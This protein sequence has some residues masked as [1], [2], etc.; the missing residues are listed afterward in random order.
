[1]VIEIVDINKS[2]TALVSNN[3]VLGYK[4]TFKCPIVS[5]QAVVVPYTNR[6]DALVIGKKL[7]VETSQEAVY[8]FKVVSNGTPIKVRPL[9]EPGDYHI[10]GEIVLNT[11]NTV[12]D[13]E[14]DD[15]SF[16]IDIEESDGLIPNLGDK[17]SF[18][19]HGLAL[20]DENV[21]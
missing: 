7:S 16:T 2:S 1:M 18:K 9:N 5:G 10:I 4:C 6:E 19:I 3:K 11:G 20:W 12:F 15:F 21:I 17:V 8:G 14:V 13:I